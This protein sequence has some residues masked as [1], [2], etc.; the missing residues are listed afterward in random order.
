LQR[1][2][3]I[4]IKTQHFSQLKHRFIGRAFHHVQV[5][6]IHPR[7]RKP[8]LDLQHLQKERF[9]FI[10]SVL[11]GANGAHQI[12]HVGRVGRGA[13]N[14]GELSFSLKHAVVANER[15]DVFEA[16]GKLLVLGRALKTNRDR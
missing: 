7:R 5:T 4:R 2:G 3:I 12:E 8:L 13:R 11:L 15:G 6:E 10:E 16:P 1:L 9:G 14:R